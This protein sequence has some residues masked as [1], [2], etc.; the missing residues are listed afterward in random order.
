MSRRPPP[1]TCAQCGADI[2]ARALACP[3]CGADERTGWDE[4][5]VYDGLDLPDDQDAEQA[6]RRGHGVRRPGEASPIWLYVA[7]V[8][9]VVL[10]LAVLGLRPW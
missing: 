1:P 7:L 6:P 8:L 9:I 10:G 2:P 4:Q 3:E 5:S